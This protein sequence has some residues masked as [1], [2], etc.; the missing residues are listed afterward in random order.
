MPGFRPFATLIRACALIAAT[1]LPL[2]A[3]AP[4]AAAEGSVSIELNK[5]E[6]Q[7]TGCRTYLVLQNGTAAAFEELR[8]DI[9][10]FDTDGI[11]AKRLAVEAGPLPV[12]KTSLKLFTMSGLACDT[13]GRLLL[14]NVLS[15]VDQSGKRTDCVG[16]L[17]ISTRATAPFI[18]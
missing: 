8:L 7:E 15:C 9:A 2:A 16:L 1:L 3:A 10:V 12:G 4:S 6:P 18:K 17:E 11:V 13:V 5:L 14:N